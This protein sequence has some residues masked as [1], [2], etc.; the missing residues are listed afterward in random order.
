MTWPSVN[1]TNKTMIKVLE[2]PKLSVGRNGSST[3]TRSSSKFRIFLPLSRFR[4]NSIN[5]IN[6]NY[7]SRFFF[8]FNSTKI[9]PCVQCAFNKKTKKKNPKKSNKILI[10]IM[11]RLNE[12][13]TLIYA[14]INCLF[15]KA[16]NI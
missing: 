13:L 2:I 8:Y 6:I 3:L 5:K 12:S 11:L 9:Q 14:T 16:L 4:Q 15:I 10:K 7:I 1:F